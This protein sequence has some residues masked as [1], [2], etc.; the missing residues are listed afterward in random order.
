MNEQTILN[1]VRNAID[2]LTRLS[3]K[4]K[5]GKISR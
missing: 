5:N 4:V 2:E 3:L 1:R